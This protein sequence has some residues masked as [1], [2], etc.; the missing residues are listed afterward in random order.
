M[1]VCKGKGVF[2]GIAIGKLRVHQKGELHIN[3]VS[4][5]D[6]DKE[7]Q[8]FSSAKNIAAVQLKQLYEQVIRDVGKTNA[9]I[10]Q[11]HQML[12]ED[13]NYISS[14]ENIIRT[15]LL[16]AEYAINLTTENILF[17]FAA[18]DNAYIKA[19]AADVQDISRRLIT[20]LTG[21]EEVTINSDEPVIILA[22]DLSPSETATLDR[23]K[24]LAL[25][26]VHGSSYSHT[27]ILA[28]TLNIPL[29]VG[30][31]I[32]VDSEYDGKT[33]VADGNDGF[34][35]IEPDDKIL[36]EYQKF[37]NTEELR[38]N[39]LKSLKGKENI[40]L[41]GIRID[42]DANIFHVRD[43]A[44]VIRNDAGGI[45]LFRSE[46][47]FLEK[48]DFP[49]EDEQFEV[50]RTV[51]EVMGKD[52]YS[53]IRTLDIGADKQAEYF[54]I[55][56]EENPAMGMRAIRFCLSNTDIFKTQLRAI[57]RAG[58]YGKL[59]VIYP[60]ITS[61][62][63]IKRIKAISSE[64]RKELNDEGYELRYVEEGIMIETPAAAL[65]SDLL[66]K[67]VD[68][69]SI[70]TNDLSQYTLAADRQNYNI[71]EFYNPCHTAVLRMIKIVVDNAKKAGIRV[72]ICGELA[73]DI[74]MTG[75]FLAM[76]V[77]E[78]SV[79][80]SSVLPVRKTVRETDISKI[81]EKELS[82]LYNVC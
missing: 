67:E 81:S 57:F 12:L 53:V 29:I 37:I 2:G 64:V 41:D 33:A 61:V 15:Q 70:G 35:Y 9:A 34:V 32:T 48:D 51:A 1:N 77:D 17:M 66:A 62:E 11:I 13:V 43:V 27:A 73:A 78:L 40:T 18:M 76:G 10:F 30:T 19:R 46:F 20:I 65:V 59:A 79:P 28:R 47:L 26:T 38:K 50:Y 6:P 21:G 25:V 56:H 54:N 52:R 3:R 36:S 7:W 16:N 44:S 58:K 31:E 71:D 5:S 72:G 49:S 82:G 23:D 74:N 14:I 69:F 42:I 24:V 39:E 63:E 4:I 8:R 45:G 80:P 68:F 60:M 55:P 22:D 75:L